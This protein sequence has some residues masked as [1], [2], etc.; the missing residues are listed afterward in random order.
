[1]LHSV[2]CR[3]ANLD[4]VQII[5]ETVT[6]FHRRRRSLVEAVEFLLACTLRGDTHHDSPTYTHLT[7]YTRDLLKPFATPTGDIAL[8]AKIFQ[9]V[10]QLDATI[11]KA[12][13]A[14]KNATSNTVAPTAQAQGTLGSDILTGRL[15]SLLYERRHMAI[16]LT[17]IAQYGYISPVELKAFVLWLQA[18]PTHPMLFYVLSATFISF[19]PSSPATRVGRLRP[20]LAADPSVPAFMSRTL[21]PTTQWT[22]PG[23]K[24]AI[25]LKYTMFCTEVRHQDASLENKPGFKNEELE[26][27]VWNA[28]QGDAFMYLAQSLI[29]LSKTKDGD[30]LVSSIIPRARQDTADTREVPSDENKL[31]LFSSFETLLRSLITHASSELRKIKQRQE[32]LVLANAQTDRARASSRF[33]A[34]QAQETDRAGQAPRHDIAILYSLIGLLYSSLPDERAL[35][36]WGAGGVHDPSKTTYM[37]YVESTSGRLPAFLQWAI[38]STSQQDL[39][40]LT[41][42]YEMLSGLAQGQQCSELAYNFM[43]RAT[44]EVIEGSAMSSS[45]SSGPTVSWSMIFE[46]LESWNIGALNPRGVHPPQQHSSIHTL[47][48]HAPPPP[49]AQQFQ[50]TP[51]DVRFAQS[52][53]RL[54]ATVAKH[55]IAVRTAIATNGHFRAIPMLIH[56]IPLGIPLELKGALFDTV[57]AF[58]EPGGNVDIC[59]G[60]WNLF[61]KHEI[62]NVRGSGPGKGVEVELEQIEAV[63]RLYPATIPF[64]KLLA[65]LLHTPKR[66]PE[67]DRAEGIFPPNT[68]PD[69]LGQPH[70]LPGVAPYTAFVVDNI[71]ANIPNREYATP[72]DRWLINDLALTYMER[73]LAGFNLESLVSPTQDQ[74]IRAEMLVPLIV[75]PGF[76]MMTRLL[77]TSSVQQSLL[78]YIVDGLDGFDKNFGEE[79]PYYRNT[80]VRVLRIVLRVLEVQDIFLDVLIPLLS[81]FDSAAYIGQVHHR[82]YFTKLD[83]ALSFSPSYAPALAQYMEYAMHG[84]LVYLSVRILTILSTS[85]YFSNLVTLIRRNPNSER[86]LSAFAQT[87]NIDNNEDVAEAELNV[88]L[89]T[90]AGAPDPSLED[91]EELAQGVRL[92]ALDLLVQDTD[93]GRTFPSLGHYLLMGTQDPVVQDPYA[94]GAR[95][96][97]IHVLLEL[98]GAGVPRLKDRSGGSGGAIGF[99]QW[100][101]EE[102]AQV[103]PLY[104]D[105]PALAERMYRVVYQLC[106]HPKT[107]EFSTRYLRTREDFFARQIS[108]VPS[109]APEVE[110]SPPIQIVYGD[111]AR[112]LTTVNALSSFLRVRSYIFDLVA[113]ELHILT[114]KG[115]FKSVIELL[116]ILFGTDVDY[117]EEHGF[118]T[119]REVGQSNMRIVDFFQ[120]LTFEWADSLQVEPTNMEYLANLN[121]AAC[122]RTDATGCDV[123]DRTLLLCMLAGAKKELVGQGK[124][125]TNSQFD[126]LNAE[127]AYVLESC[128]VENNRRAV[129]FSV[130]AGFEAWRRLLDIALTKCFDRL[131]HDRRENMLFDLL[132]ILPSTIRNPTIEEKT[133]VLLS[134]TAL[135][136]I[137]KLREDRR[138]QLVLQSSGAAG[139]GASLPAE[140]LYGILRDTVEG[141]LDNNHSELVRGNLYGALINFIHLVL[142]SK[143]D[144]DAEAEGNGFVDPNDPFAA[145]LAMS[146]LRE[147]S[148]FGA[149]LNQSLALSQSGRYR[150]G[151]PSSSVASA[152]LELGILSTIKPVLERLV[153]VISRDAIDG[154]EVWKTVAFMLLDAVVQLSGLEKQHPALGAMNRHGAL[155]NF[156]QGLKDADALLQAVLKPDPGAFLCRPLLSSWY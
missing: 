78:T 1:M 17:L 87:L 43:A 124:V 25:L 103:H 51:R 99:G 142:C 152:T 130:A 19:E 8:A 144:V 68:V 46:I 92:A 29:Q 56:L 154:T 48:S 126:Q 15:Q 76:D 36:F 138:Y 73:A 151:A 71:F 102:T 115:H 16:S 23:L 70:R 65:T 31:T 90:G 32:D 122:I 20:L 106:T 39:T 153:S 127:T 82:S 155:A 112:V 66:L 98:M 143:S 72:S 89:W 40:M 84:E 156:V 10:E 140:R 74:P 146:S 14:V 95:R 125:V 129:A 54:L 62:I 5:E 139:E 81:E 18:N 88:E 91:A 101:G 105:L 57:A 117:D 47:A 2:L 50:L 93:K 37:E 131:P 97:G 26:T 114:S 45:S 116:E 53:L 132:H 4:P 64:L 6:E 135:S 21:A 123:V 3:R 44:G 133:A 104:I 75:H 28:V 41:A 109:Q 145:S 69:N 137:T 118:S 42:L 121:L 12:E 150:S 27:Q 94:L 120:S 148:P 38:W 7:K 55:S 111:G 147:S 49:Q 24:A 136:L 128:V 9:A 96:T 86:I 60:V 52:F 107:A 108:C 67:K 63:H 83:Q 11:V 77:T 119:F 100:S 61:E 79:E 22:D 59:R 80:M 113:L 30:S 58:C 110:V 13:N 134:E 85:P 35:Q 33:A 34:A 141:I 149:S